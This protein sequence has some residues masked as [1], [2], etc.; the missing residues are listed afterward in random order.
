MQIFFNVFRQRLNGFLISA[1]VGPFLNDVALV[2]LHG[3][4]LPHPQQFVGLLVREGRKRDA[5]PDALAALLV[6]HIFAIGEAE[7]EAAGGTPKAGIRPSLRPTRAGAARRFLYSFC[8]SIRTLID[9]AAKI[10]RLYALDREHCLHTVKNRDKLE[11]TGAVA[12]RVPQL[13]VPS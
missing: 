13:G 6:H 10:V 11:R 7:A 4:A 5:L 8:T 2:V 3:L 9:K 1:V 12:Q